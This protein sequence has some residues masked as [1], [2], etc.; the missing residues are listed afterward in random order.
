LTLL[1]LAV[2][3]DLASWS[4]DLTVGVIDQL[5]LFLSLSLSLTNLTA[6]LAN[7]LFGSGG[8]NLLSP[9][10]RSISKGVVLDGIT[11]NESVSVQTINPSAAGCEFEPDVVVKV[12]VAVTQGSDDSLTG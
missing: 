11:N 4:V 9:V 1:E 10:V 7:R 6:L 8:S 2:D 12:N 5:S 3:I